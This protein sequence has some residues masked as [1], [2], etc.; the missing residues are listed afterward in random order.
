MKAICNI[1][2]ICVPLAFLFY[3]KYL[4]LSSSQIGDVSRYVQFFN[5]DTSSF[6]FESIFVLFHYLVSAYD[7]NP[8]QLFSVIGALS[9]SLII[10]QSRVLIGAYYGSIGGLLIVTLFAIL[11]PDSPLFSTFL[12][13]WRFLYGFLFLLLGTLLLQSP[14]SPSSSARP[15][16]SR[17]LISLLFFILAA[18][19]HSATLILSFILILIHFRGHAIDSLLSFLYRIKFRRF[20]F[21]RVKVFSVLISFVLLFLVFRLASTDYFSSRISHYSD[22]SS[23][24]GSYFSVF[25]SV[26]LSSA[27]SFCIVSF[28]PGCTLGPLAKAYAVLP[29]FLVPLLLFSPA[30][31]YRLSS[32]YYF[33][34]FICLTFALTAAVVRLC[35]WREPLPPGDSR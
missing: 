16:K 29:V 27:T 21:A 19:S 7:I 35:S 12:S 34:G 22:F 13:A 6:S 4:Y 30:S 5:S 28:S 25:L 2:F 31:A 14:G 3:S 33:L 32:Q 20:H 15:S 9:L 23:F 24:E 26:A 1:L 18:I 17:N 10:V 11:P 8:I